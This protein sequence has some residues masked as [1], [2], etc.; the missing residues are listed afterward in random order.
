MSSSREPSERSSWACTSGLG[1]SAAGPGARSGPM[2]ATVYDDSPEGA[3][4]FA[5]SV[6]HAQ[7]MSQGKYEPKLAWTAC[8]KLEK[9]LS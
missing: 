8:K 4:R 2:P 7:V 5:L 6:L 3:M 1:G 9:A